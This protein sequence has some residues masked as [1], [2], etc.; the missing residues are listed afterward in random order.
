MVDVVDVVLNGYDLYC[1][2][3][4]DIAMFSMEESKVLCARCSP[5]EDTAVKVPGQSSVEAFREENNNG[6]LQ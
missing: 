6:E 5:K 3:C 1:E 4:G 2:G